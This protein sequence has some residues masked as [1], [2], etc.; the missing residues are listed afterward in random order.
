[1]NI[2][3]K[4]EER[5]WEAIRSSYE[6][7]NYTGAIQNSMYFLSDL[8]REKSGLD[9]DGVPL[10]S[11]AFGGKNP[12]LKVNKLKTESEKN[13]QKG[14]D[15]LLRGL[16]QAVRNP[17]SHEHHTDSED[18][19]AAIILFINYL[20][21]IID[22]SKTPFLENVFISRVLDSDFVPSDRYARLL[23]YEIPE[24]KRMDIFYGVLKRISEGEGEKL[25][26]FFN[27]L[28]HLLTQEEKEEIYKE[29]SEVL[30]HTSNNGVISLIIEAFSSIWPDLEESARL[31][32]ENKLIE[33]IIDG[34]SNLF[35]DEL[36]GGHL[37]TFTPNIIK[38]FALREEL[39]NV[40]LNKLESRD[41]EEQEYVFDYFSN[42]FIKLIT[43][44]DP[45][46]ERVITNG[47][48]KGDIR[49]KK[50]V[51][52]NFSERGEE[53]IST[54]SEA[55]ENFEEKTPFNPYDDDL[56]F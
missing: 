47:L 21:K 25:G 18:D 22:Q 4:I 27:A 28:F 36:S 23:V 2:E 3:T 15:Q 37:G 12:K 10:V 35:K 5:L 56:P 50:L 53:W 20:V 51:E 24:K 54:F 16:Y 26:Y 46:L 39:Y 33:S 30:K 43:Y 41:T 29:I 40:L 42:F 44:I 38:H 8:I 9:G 48:K 32:I 52:I 19:A 7:R 1:M 45:S 49:F 13:V 11:Q 14:V 34:R 31:R 6:S 55:L 17:R